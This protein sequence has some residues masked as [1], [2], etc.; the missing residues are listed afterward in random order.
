MVFTCV[1]L[2]W[3]VL[4]LGRGDITSK[5]IQDIIYISNIIFKHQR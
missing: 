2:A 4:E 3:A 5:N 1:A